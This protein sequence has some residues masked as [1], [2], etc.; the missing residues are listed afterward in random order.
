M[1][2]RILL[3]T[4]VSLQTHRLLGSSVVAVAV[5]VVA[6]VV[7]TATVV[8]AETIRNNPFG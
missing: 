6:A 5:T 1:A 3:Q 4:L 8:L 7:V 2:S